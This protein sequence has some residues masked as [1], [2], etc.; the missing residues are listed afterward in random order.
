M[1]KQDQ[2]TR[3]LTVAITVP[4]TV[5]EFDSCAGAT[6][7]A[8]AFANAESIYRSILPKAWK[9]VFAAA[10]V[11]WGITR[12]QVGTK[13]N[14]AGEELPVLESDKDFGAKLR[15]SV[16]A[17]ELQAYLQG[18]CDEIGFDVSKTGRSKKPAAVFY[19]QADQLL[20]KVAG[21]E[22]D[23]DTIQTGITNLGLTVEIETSE[24]GSIDRDSLAE[25]LQ[26]VF[27]NMA[28][29]GLG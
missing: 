19:A 5:E 10:E 17:P 25:A 26:V 7:A 24:D 6:G 2:S 23:L 29:P 9:A 22:T 16:E 21:G 12:E 28:L 8:L 3:G 13:T 15:A 20:A 4:E 18:C 27:K 11:Q 1:K 14:K